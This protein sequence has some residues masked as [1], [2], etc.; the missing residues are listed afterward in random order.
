MLENVRNLSSYHVV[1]IG[2]H[3]E[4]FNPN[5]LHHTDPAPKM[6]Y[7]PPETVTDDEFKGILAHL[8]ILLKTLPPPLPF[9]SLSE[10]AFAPFHNF[11]AD[12]ETLE[13]TGCEVAVLGEDLER[14][15]GWKARLTGDGILP[16]M[17]RGP[18]INSLH[19][20]FSK[21]Y[22]KH[23]GNNVLKK[24]IQIGQWYGKHEV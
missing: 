19:H 13:K 5:Y 2:G 23:R 12:P 22:A 8:D 7:P 24:M 21:L 16:I 17:E 20:A 3:N 1:I 4:K 11:E 10:S 18:G 9:K 14:V 6:L 15:F